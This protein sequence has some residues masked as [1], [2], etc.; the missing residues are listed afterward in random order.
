LLSSSRSRPYRIPR[1]PTRTRPPLG[2]DGHPGTQSTRPCSCA[3]CALALQLCRPPGPR[4][5]PPAKTPR[6]AGGARLCRGWRG[7]R[8]PPGDFWHL[9][10]RALGAGF[11]EQVLVW[12]V[13]FSCPIPCPMSHILCCGYKI[14]VI[15]PLTLKTISHCIS[16]V[17]QLE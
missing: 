7:S 2:A 1:S 5:A 9:G 15:G 14:A 8:S 16:D 4:E 17:A 10:R 13:L 12:S 6:G 3:R 11:W